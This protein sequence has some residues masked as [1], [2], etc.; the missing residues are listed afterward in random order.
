MKLVIGYVMTN[1]GRAALEWGIEEAKRHGAELIVVHSIRGGGPVEEEEKEILAYREELDAIENRL[2][3]AGITH[4][5]RRL[6]RGLSPAEDLVQTAAEEQADMIVI[7]LRRRSRAGKFFVGGD[8][9]EILHR[10]E[11]PVLCV[12]A[13][14][15]K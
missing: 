2:T 12:K 14:Y 1:E 10:A 9:Q 6:I 13:T 4:H 8:A 5:T 3:K 15:R 11:C 7:G